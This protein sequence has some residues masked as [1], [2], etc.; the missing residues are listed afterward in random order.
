MHAVFY[1][2]VTG[3]EADPKTTFRIMRSVNDAGANG[4]ASTKGDTVVEE[5]TFPKAEAVRRRREFA[6]K[7]DQLSG[8]PSV[9]E[10]VRASLV[11]A[12]IIAR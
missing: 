8:R 3:K 10:S 2:S 4:W 5:R 9:F 12:G 6:A 7:V 1:L 11:L